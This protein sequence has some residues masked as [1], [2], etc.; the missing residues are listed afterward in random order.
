VSDFAGIVV[1]GRRAVMMAM[2][3]MV[4]DSALAIFVFFDS[5]FLQG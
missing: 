2:G 1:H 5:L 4:F 3:P